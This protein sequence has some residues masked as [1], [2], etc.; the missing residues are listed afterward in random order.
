[1]AE[2]DLLARLRAHLSAPAR[3]VLAACGRICRQQGAS[4]FLVGGGVRDLLLGRETIDLDLAVESDVAPIAQALAQVTHG[5]AVFHPRFGTATVSGAGFGLDLAR[6]RRETYAHPGALPSVEPATI[7]ADLARRDFTINALALRLTPPAGELIDPHGGLADLRR[8]RVRALHDASFQDDATRMLRAVRYAA[9]LEFRIARETEALIRRDLGYLATIS[10]PRLRRELSLLFEE[11]CAVEGALRAQ[12]LGVL[13]AVHPSL[14]LAANLAARWREALAG[15]HFAPV[16]QL[17][18]CV[19]ADVADAAAVVSLSARLHL[20]GRL[21]RALSDLVRLSGLSAKLASAQSP[22]RAVEL[23]EN[24]AAAA[25]WALALRGDRAVAEACFAYLRE[26][27]R[28]RPHLTGHD[29]LALGVAP[30]IAVGETLRRL[31]Q[32]RLEG[33]A[34]TRQAELELVRAELQG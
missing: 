9:R 32:A 7:A 5:R 17:G 31:R 12:R 19:V 25:V 15:H 11:A 20:T 6:T 16:E 30:G 1:M 28:V 26:W 22:A 21:E 34:P 33:R 14:R 4:L 10:G 18:Y 3:R 13:Q 8:H 2:A 29:L 27:R 23:L 24:R